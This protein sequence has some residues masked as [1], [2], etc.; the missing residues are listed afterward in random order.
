[1]QNK[2]N[3]FTDTAISLEVCGPKTHFPGFL[4]YFATSDLTTIKRAEAKLDQAQ[5]KLRLNLKLEDFYRKRINQFDDTKSSHQP[6]K[7]C[8]F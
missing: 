5:L 1:M 2:L 3:I 8:F 6:D 7:L 4:T